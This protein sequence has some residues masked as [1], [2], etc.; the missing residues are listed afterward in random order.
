MMNANNLGPVLEAE[1]AEGGHD[2]IFVPHC[3]TCQVFN[4]VFPTYS[5]PCDC[6]GSEHEAHA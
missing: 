4:Q 5:G 6:T 2:G 1:H 3:V